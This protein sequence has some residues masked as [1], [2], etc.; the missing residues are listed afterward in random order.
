[1]WLETHP[2]PGAMSIEGSR[3]RAAVSLDPSAAD[4]NQPTATRGSNYT[5]SR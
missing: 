3:A 5:A 4:A 1:L 2:L